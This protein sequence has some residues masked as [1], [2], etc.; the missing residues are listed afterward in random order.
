MP[1]QPTAVP[2][3]AI[4]DGPGPVHGGPDYHFIILAPGI[5][6]EWF[7]QAAEPYWLRFHPV[8]LEDAGYIANMP[9]DKSLAVT[10]VAAPDQVETMNQQVRDAWPNVWYDLIVA[11]QAN[12][13]VE[14]FNQRVAS[15][16]RFG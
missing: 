4:P 1:I 12:V 11:E 5:E 15:G 10:V 14:V 13:L 8:L 9:Y 2:T 7:F 3:P 6:P 16:R